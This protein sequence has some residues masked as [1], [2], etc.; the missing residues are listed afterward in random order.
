MNG[1]IIFGIFIILNFILVYAKSSGAVPF[2][3]IL[4]LFAM[5]LLISAPLC[6]LGAY[7]GFKKAVSTFPT[8]FEFFYISFSYIVI[9]N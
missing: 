8:Y 4:G 5:W 7:F 1:R 9:E 6:A 3:T 2:G